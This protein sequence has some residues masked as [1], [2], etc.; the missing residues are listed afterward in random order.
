MNH[1]HNIANIIVNS[2]Y[3]PKEFVK[4]IV[5]DELGRD[6]AYLTLY[7]NVPLA[8][9]P[10]ITKLQRDFLIYS[11]G[12]MVKV[13]AS[14]V[15]KDKYEW[16]GETITVGELFKRTGVLIPNGQSG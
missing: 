7:F 5:K 12:E 15:Y 9:I 13:K 2:S 11:K 14:D 10:D 8:N 3:R 1:I 16:S 6:V 4:Q